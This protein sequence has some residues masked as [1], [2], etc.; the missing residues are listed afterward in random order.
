M[1]LTAAVT[2]IV[3]ALL[4][5]GLAKC[6]RPPLPGIPYNERNAW[7]PFGDI[8][9]LVRASTP[10]DYFSQHIQKYGAV[11]Q[12]LLGPLGPLVLVSDV[13]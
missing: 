4:F 6:W 7:Y 8:L 11:C 5:V 1:A 2:V 3:I 10:V 9:D 12:V 13:Q